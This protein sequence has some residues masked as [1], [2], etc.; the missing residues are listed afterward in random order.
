MKIRY[1]IN[2][3]ILLWLA[4]SSIPLML[5]G[6]FIIDQLSYQLYAELLTKELNH[7]VYQDIFNEDLN[8][9]ATVHHHE[10]ESNLSAL[11]NIHHH[12]INDLGNTSSFYL[13]D[14]HFQVILHQDYSPGQVFAFDFAK[15]MLQQREGK[16]HYIYQGEPHFAIFTTL[17]QFDWLA[18]LAITEAEM[19][20]Y[21]DFY[22]Q[23]VTIFGSVMILI[24]LLF[25]LVFSRR[26]S[27]KIQ[28]ILQFLTSLLRH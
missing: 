28:T 2:L 13:L 5:F 15:K 4:V 9:I 1:Q 14:S 11:A 23:W 17:P 3:F 8:S 16:I 24:V 20:A 22:R 7:I 21:R 18:V 25:A 6:Y 10:N 27:K 12:L 19:F 26:L